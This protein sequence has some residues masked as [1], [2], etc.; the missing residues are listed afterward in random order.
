MRE[1]DKSESV[2]GPSLIIRGDIQ[3][4][5]T[6]RIDGVVEGTISADGSI[7]VAKGGTARG[8]ITS[9][10]IIAGG[11]IEG[12]VIAREKMEILPTGTLHGD[13]VTVVYG[14]VIHEGAIFDGS[15]KMSKPT[16]Q[17]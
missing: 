3:S 13:V 11:T 12:N 7:V 5:G 17:E 8:D 2:I 15:C 1:P 9:D 10:N 14:L 4:S 16:G 6:L